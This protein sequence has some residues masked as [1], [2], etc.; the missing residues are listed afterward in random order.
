MTATATAEATGVDNVLQVLKEANNNKDS[1]SREYNLVVDLTSNELGQSHLF[2][3]WKTLNDED[4]D[5]L[6]DFLDQL[7]QLDEAYPGGLRQYIL[8]AKKLL[9]GESD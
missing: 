7:V 1:N 3:K 2:D 6:H 4:L 9:E 8:K 5:L